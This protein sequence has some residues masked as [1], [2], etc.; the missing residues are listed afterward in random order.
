MKLKKGDVVKASLTFE[1]SGVTQGEKGVP[2]ASGWATDDGGKKSY[3]TLPLYAI[4][5]V[6][7]SGKILERV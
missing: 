4:E 6:I 7:E 3:V 5:E 1:L 2:F